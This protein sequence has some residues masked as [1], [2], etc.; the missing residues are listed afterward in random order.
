LTTVL[1]DPMHILLLVAS[2]CRNSF[3]SSLL[4]SI[5]RNRAYNHLHLCVCVCELVR[6]SICPNLVMYSYFQICNQTRL[7]CLLCTPCFLLAA[8]LMHVHMICAS[9]ASSHYLWSMI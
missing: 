1:V 6:S 4:W 5:R 7:G 9:N 2:I 8:D 3:V